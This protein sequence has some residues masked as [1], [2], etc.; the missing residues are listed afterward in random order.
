MPVSYN[1]TF[2]KTS[3]KL[4]RTDNLSFGKHRFANAHCNY[5]RSE[6]NPAICRGFTTNYILNYCNGSIWQA[7]KYPVELMYEN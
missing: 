1:N 7:A 2:N 6:A 4:F 5:S 3:V